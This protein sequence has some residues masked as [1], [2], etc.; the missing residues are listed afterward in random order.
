MESSP[1]DSTSAAEQKAAR[2]ARLLRN[3]D[4]ALAAAA[5]LNAATTAAFPEASAEVERTFPRD[6][7]S[8]TVSQKLA[9]GDQTAGDLAELAFNLDP[10]ATMDTL[11]ASLPGDSVSLGA[12]TSVIVKAR[13][14]ASQ[15]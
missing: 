9:L 4:V 13:A 14:G 12:A 6:L 11:E 5:Q 1:N 10:E 2:R 8:L 15:A 7:S 3:L